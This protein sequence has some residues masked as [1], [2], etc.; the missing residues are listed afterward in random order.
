[1]MLPQENYILFEVGVNFDNSMVTHKYIVFR[2]ISSWTKT[3]GKC[4]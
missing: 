4:V 1:M 3:V 2:N